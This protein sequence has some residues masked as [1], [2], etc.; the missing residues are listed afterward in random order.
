MNSCLSLLWDRAD[1]PDPVFTAD[2]VARWEPGTLKELEELRLLVVAET[3]GSVVCD[4]CSDDHVEEVT[5]LEGREPGDA[6]RGFIMCSEAGRVS[7]DAGRLRRW[8]IDFGAV[9]RL[10]AESL[11]CADQV[12]EVVR[13]RAWLIGQAF[14]GGLWREVYLFRGASWRD[15]DDVA[16]RAGA[17]G[18]ALIFVPGAVPSAWREVSWDVVPLSGV[19]SIRDDKLVVDPSRVSAILPASPR[20]TLDR[21][22]KPVAV[23]RVKSHFATRP[24]L[25]VLRAGNKHRH[26]INDLSFGGNECTY[27]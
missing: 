8:R 5:W 11:E 9:A 6:P 7:V 13:S 4:A 22:L 25:P 10:V 1:T 15:S 3:A 14:V 20:A 16:K 26:R 27:P 12:R 2:E 21:V 23:P 19:I 18:R 17:L 24:G